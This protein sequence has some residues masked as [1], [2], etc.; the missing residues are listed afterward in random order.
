MI[1][2]QPWA[3]SASY[4]LKLDP[5]IAQLATKTTRI[6][7]VSAMRIVLHIHTKIFSPKCVMIAIKFAK[8]A[9]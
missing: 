7:M 6:Q 8:I 4:Y 9:V 3:K 1:I 5:A 2:L